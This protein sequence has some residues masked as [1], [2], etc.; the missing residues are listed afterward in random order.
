MTVIT[1]DAMI[2][3]GDF[4]YTPLLLGTTLH[5]IDQILFPDPGWTPLS[6]AR[7]NQGESLVSEFL[8]MMLCQGRGSHL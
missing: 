6:G 4:E 1:E 3:K 2:G 7:E 5:L 8:A